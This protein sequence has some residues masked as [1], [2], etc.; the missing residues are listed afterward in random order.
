MNKRFSAALF[1]LTMATAP[2]FAQD[3]DQVR[4]RVIHAVPQASA[5]TV[6][7]G[8]TPLFQN[9]A[10]NTVTP[11]KPM[12]QQD[13]QKVTL[14]LAD[15]R[16]LQT[17]DQLDFDDSNEEYTILVTPD[18]DGPNPKVVVLKG[19]IENVDAD[20]AEVTLINAAPEHKSVKLMLDDDTEERGVNYAESDDSDVKPGVYTLKV[21]DTEGTNQI[22]ASRKVTLPG[23]SAIS[24]ILTG[25][26][27]VKIVNDK[28]PMTDMAAAGMSSSSESTTRTL[29]TMGAMD[30]MTTGSHS[31]MP[32]MTGPGSNS[33]GSTESQMNSQMQTPSSTM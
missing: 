7:V 20:E 14:N 1:A 30:H 28:S 24:V 16:Q 26:N 23:G 10:F 25:A 29:G 13:D 32:G 2:L 22:I 31:S 15:G 27:S 19:D 17:T 18:P 12:A 3:N 33:Q 9:V 4:V 5:V 6:K 8:D 11:F 21:V